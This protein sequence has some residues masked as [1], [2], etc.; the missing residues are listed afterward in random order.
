MRSKFRPQVEIN[1]TRSNLKLTKAYY[2]QYEAVSSILDANPQILDRVHE[3]LEKPLQYARSQTGSGKSFRYTTEQVLRILMCQILEGESLRGIVV[4]IDDSNFLRHFVHLYN[5]PMMDYT[6]LCK[7]KNSIRPETW[8]EIN[9]HLA[10]YAVEQELISGDKLRMDTT[11]VETNIHW[12]TDSSLLWDVYRT[13][14]RLMEQAREIDS[15]AVVNKRLHRKRTKRVYTK[16]SRTANKKGKK[17]DTLKPLYKDLIERVE[18]I[19]AWASNVAA[20]LQV[21]REAKMYSL[22][23]DVEVAALI[24]EIEVFLQRGHRVVDQARRRVL[25]GES[26]PNDEKIFSIFEV[27]TE[28]LKRGKARKEIE[29][30]HMIQIQQVP[31]KFITD[32]EVFEKKPVEHRLLTP[33]VENHKKL[34]KHYPKEVSADKGYYE[35]MQ[36]LEELQRKIPVV[37][38]GKKGKRDPQQEERER[39]PLFKLAQRFRAGVEGSISFLKRILRLH[40]C[41]NKGWEHFA[42]TIGQT[43]FAHNLLILARL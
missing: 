27:H 32:Y 33:A 41:F 36:A 21:G 5:G 11:A 28:L 38:I 8:H 7:L 39:N 40:R 9:K 25:H 4:R 34:F 13:L 14:A 42:A 17:R 23:V 43:V 37:S 2:A 29:F 19:C 1:F 16:I 10:T 15:A 22:L 30:V 24:S 20:T 35:N 12:P 6:T 3:D 31:E 26:V 18:G